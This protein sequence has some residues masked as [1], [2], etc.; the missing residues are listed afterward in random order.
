MFKFVIQISCRNLVDE[1]IALLSS[2]PCP[3]QGF[4]TGSGHCADDQ[5]SSEQGSSVSCAMYL[6]ESFLCCHY[7]TTPP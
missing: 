4:K 7:P 2:V 5:D 3:G 6:G 1:F